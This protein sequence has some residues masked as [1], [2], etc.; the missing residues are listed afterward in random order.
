MITIDTHP[1]PFALHVIAARLRPEDR[2]ELAVTRDIEDAET[3]VHDA[4]LARYGY[5]AVAMIDRVPVFA[6]GVVPAPHLDHV[7][8]WAFGT[9]ESPRV[10]R[11]VTKHIKKIMVPK[12]I[13]L[14]VQ[15]VQAVSHP[16]NFAAHRWLRHLGFR[17]QARLSDIGPRNEDMLLFVGRAP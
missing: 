8:A 9:V 7:N 4:F 13:S 15:T 14:G 3:L 10:L 6:F 17:L 11:E 16:E 5:I 2:H 12:L 1:T